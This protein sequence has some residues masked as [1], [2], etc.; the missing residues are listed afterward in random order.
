M[1]KRERNEPTVAEIAAFIQTISRLTLSD[2]VQERYAKSTRVV[3]GSELAA[4]RAL[5]R[6]GSLTYGDLA[7]RLGLDRTTIS[8]LAV[9]LLEL[10]LVEREND[11]RDKRKAW[12]HLTRSG[13]KVLQ[14]V[15]AVYLGYYEVAISDWNAE[16]RAE[17]RR[18]LARLR[19]DLTHLEFDDTGRATRVRPDQSSKSA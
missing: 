1:A 2:R 14:D 5:N 3:G 13:K 6:A 4:L 11:E 16:E 18:V 12:L 19:H 15:E 8:R 10:E 17:A 7:D 9:R